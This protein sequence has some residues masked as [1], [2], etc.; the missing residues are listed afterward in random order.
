MLATEEDDINQLL[1]AVGVKFNPKGNA[2]I[3]VNALF[4]VRDDGLTNEDA[5]V[6]VAWDQTF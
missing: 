3:T 2:V 4:S 6:L 1:A 5:I